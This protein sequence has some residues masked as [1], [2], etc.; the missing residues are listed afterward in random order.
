M[1]RSFFNH[2]R[3]YLCISTQRLD[4]SP[5]PHPCLIRGLFAFHVGFVKGGRWGEQE[6]K[7]DLIIISWYAIKY[8]HLGLQLVIMSREWIGIEA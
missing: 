7:A 2:L 6:S 1:I 5:I 3:D 4:G 8:V